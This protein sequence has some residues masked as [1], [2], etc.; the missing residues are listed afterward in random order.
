M[1]FIKKVLEHI[2]NLFNGKK[3]VLK[4]E[5]GGTRIKNDERNKFLNGLKIKDILNSKNKIETL[6]CYGD[7]LGRKNK[8][9]Y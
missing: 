2:F 5:E 8:I 1:N 3:E 7:G 4:L 9:K 6:L